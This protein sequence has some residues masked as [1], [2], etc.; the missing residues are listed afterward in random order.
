MKNIL[1]D[2]ELGL[3]LPREVQLRRIQRVMEQELTEVQRQTLMLYYFEDKRLSE[4]AR[5]QG[6]HRSTALRTL[7]RAE[8]RLRRYLRY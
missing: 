5:I 7:R 2:S 1:Y 6:I 4:I 8:D 3:N